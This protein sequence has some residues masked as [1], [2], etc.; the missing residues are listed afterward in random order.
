MKFLATSTAPVECPVHGCNVA[1]SCLELGCGDVSN[2][3][4]LPTRGVGASEAKNQPNLAGFY[5]I[6]ADWS[7]FSLFAIV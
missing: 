7:L 1:D 6:L 2:P 4:Q 3:Y 5:L